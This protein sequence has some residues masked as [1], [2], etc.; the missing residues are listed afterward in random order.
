MNNTA[1]LRGLKVGPS[2]A[3][4]KYKVD[5][6]WFTKE[7]CNYR[8]W[9]YSEFFL[10]GAFKGNQNREAW[11]HHLDFSFITIFKIHVKIILFAFKSNDITLRC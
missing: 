3:Q 5:R 11:T 6:G 9:S 10:K 7:E 8:L 2:Q 1:I 4:Q